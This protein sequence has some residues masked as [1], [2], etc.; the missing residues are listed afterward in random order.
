MKVIYLH[1]FASSPESSKARF[2]AAQFATLGVECVVPALDGGDFRNLTITGQL[3]IVEREAAANT[4]P[5]RLI[6]SSLGGYLSALYAALHPEQVERLVLLAPAFCFGSHYPRELGPA[7]MEAWKNTGVRRIPHYGY[8]EERD[9]AYTFIEDAASYPDNPDFRQPALIFHGKNDDVVPV[10]LSEAFAAS[11]PNA[12]LRVLD[13]DHQLT[14]VT[15]V[16]WNE[17]SAFFGL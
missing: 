12:K 16:L 7:T 11:H 10:H 8:G 2:F 3:A 6:G 1:G 4:G 15:E 9:L 13:S 5:V 17:T 14:D